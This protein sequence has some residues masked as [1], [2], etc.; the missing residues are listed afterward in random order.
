MFCTS[1]PSDPALKKGL[2]MQ[3]VL[4]TNITNASKVSREEIFGPVCSIIKVEK[5]EGFVGDFCSGMIMKR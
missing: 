5:K 2:F 3:P 4:L 1:L